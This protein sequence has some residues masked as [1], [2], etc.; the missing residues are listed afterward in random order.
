MFCFQFSFSES[1]LLNM[2]LQKKGDKIWLHFR[3]IREPYDLSSFT[4]NDIS[5]NYQLLKA[6]I[7]DYQYNYT[8]GMNNLR[9]KFDLLKGNLYEKNRCC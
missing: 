5:E 7:P 9:I 2:L 3:S 6:L 4:K 8:M 1:N